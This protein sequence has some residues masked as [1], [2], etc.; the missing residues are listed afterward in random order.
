MGAVD[1]VSVY[2]AGI[3]QRAA[4][5]CHGMH[6]AGGICRVL[7]ARTGYSVRASRG[8]AAPPVGRDAAGQLDRY[9]GNG[10]CG[11]D[12]LLYRAAALPAHHGDW[13]AFESV[14]V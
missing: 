3:V 12:L 9:A 6:R 4:F 1:L 10:G 11:G 8:C 13:P 14:V 7:L 5:D 2:L